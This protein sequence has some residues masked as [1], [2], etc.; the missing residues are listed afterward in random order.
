MTGI[1]SEWNPRAH[2]AALPS[3][4]SAVIVNLTEPPLSQLNWD[5]QH[6]SL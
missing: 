6:R 3:V 1:T 2:A 4:A 5:L